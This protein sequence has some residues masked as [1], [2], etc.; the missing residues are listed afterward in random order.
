MNVDTLYRIVS[1]TLKDLEGMEF[2]EPC[3]YIVPTYNASLKVA[4]KLFPDDEFLIELVLFE[5]GEAGVNQLKILFRQ[6]KMILSMYLSSA[7]DNEEA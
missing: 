6:L 2:H 4:K 3:Q 1:V 7:P 5:N